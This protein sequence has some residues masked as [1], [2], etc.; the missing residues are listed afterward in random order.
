MVTADTLVKELK[1]NRVSATLRETWD[2]GDRGARTTALST[3]KEGAARRIRTLLGQ[4]W[5]PVTV[6]GDKNYHPDE[7]LV[8]DLEEGARRGGS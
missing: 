1:N 3:G 2:R 8:V 6:P 5:R 4:G 7:D